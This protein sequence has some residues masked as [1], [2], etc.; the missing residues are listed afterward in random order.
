M[1]Y[2]NLCRHCRVC[3][4]AKM[5]SVQATGRAH[6]YMSKVSKQAYPDCTLKDS[7]CIPRW[8]RFLQILLGMRKL[9]YLISSH[10]NMSPDDYFVKVTSLLRS[11]ASSRVS[12]QR[13]NNL[14]ISPRSLIRM[15]PSGSWSTWHLCL[16]PR[17]LYLF[18][19]F[20]QLLAHSFQP[21]QKTSHISA[22][23][24]SRL[25]KVFQ[26]ARQWLKR[27]ISNCPGMDLVTRGWLSVQRVR[28]DAWKVIDQL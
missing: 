7:W 22:K 4:G 20:A 25:S 12:M 18:R 27:L 19:C 9:E 5:W 3:K 11:C 17:I 13:P 24:V 16:V 21:Y 23:M 1:L 26:L 6:I 8:H 10:A 15:I 28:E 14:G 2:L